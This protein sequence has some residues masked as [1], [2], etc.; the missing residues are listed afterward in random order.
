[1]Y[2]LLQQCN[3]EV[4]D[5]VLPLLLVS[6]PSSVRAEVGQAGSEYPAPNQ[7]SGWRRW[8]TSENMEMPR[9]Q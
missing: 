4:K 1:M 7:S 9:V 2:G 3:S 8:R 6:L 5:M